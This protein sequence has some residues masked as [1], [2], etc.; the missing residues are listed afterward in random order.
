VLLARRPGLQVVRSLLL[1]GSTM[2]NFLALRQLQLAETSTIS[3]LQPMFVALLAGPLLGE[4][5]GGARLVAIAVGF[6]GVVIAT[7]PGADAFQPVVLLAI[8]GV[9]CAAVYALATRRLAAHDSPETT[10]AWTQVA[11]I[12]LLTPVLPWVWET[13]PTAF[14]WAVMAAMGGC[15]ALGH[16][17]LILA[18]Q[19]APAPVLTPFNYT[20][21]IWMI[22][23]GVLV[24]GDRPPGATLLG[25]GLVV[26]CGLFLVMYER[27][28]RIGD[29]RRLG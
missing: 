16:G 3:F 8:G 2:A 25:A 26:A 20:Q 21:L 17:L 10:L 5:V 9:A 15:A 6:L 24:F 13:P 1:F 18:H 27:Q 4:S 11:G 23:S 14:A 12:A 19:R 29:A 28:G 7:R 22:V